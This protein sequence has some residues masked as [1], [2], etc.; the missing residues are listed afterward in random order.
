M[1]INVMQS[2]NCLFALN[3]SLI[4]SDDGFVANAGC[5]FVFPVFHDGNEFVLSEDVVEHCEFAALLT[6]SIIRSRE[7][8]TFVMKSLQEHE[9]P[10]C[11]DFWRRIA[12][13]NA[14]LSVVN[15]L[16]LDK[17]S[18]FLSHWR[19]KLI[20]SSSS[21]KRGTGGRSRTPSS[22]CRSSWTGSARTDVEDFSICIASTNR[23]SQ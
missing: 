14:H 2:V 9:Q 20:S 5:S 18:H 12:L 17:V 13:T 1:I 16:S 21:H 22:R 6:L 19:Q 4:N 23:P 15:F 3:D 8:V 7:S 11:L 10:R